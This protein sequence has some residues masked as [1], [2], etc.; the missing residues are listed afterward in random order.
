MPTAQRLNINV[1]KAAKLKYQNYSS[2]L[3]DFCEQ[4]LNIFIF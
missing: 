2:S 4:V 3:L 1:I